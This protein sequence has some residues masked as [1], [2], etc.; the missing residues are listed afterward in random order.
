MDRPLDPPRGPTSDPDLDLRNEA[1][2]HPNRL[3]NTKELRAL[4]RELG[5]PDRNQLVDPHSNQRYVENLRAPTNQHNFLFGRMP[6]FESRLEALRAVRDEDIPKLLSLIS[7]DKEEIRANHRIACLAHR[8]KFGTSLADT[9]GEIL[10]NYPDKNR[11][12]GRTVAVTGLPGSGAKEVAADLTS[13]LNKRIGAVIAMDPDRTRF[14]LF[15]AAVRDVEVGA[16]NDTSWR[17][18]DKARRALHSPAV[19]QMVYTV[20]EL[21][22]IAL[23]ARGYNLVISQGPYMVP[24]PA[25]ALYAEHPTIELADV[26]DADFRGVFEPLSEEQSTSFYATRAEAREKVLY[27]TLQEMDRLRFPDDFP[28]QEITSNKLRTFEEMP[29]VNIKV[30]QDA[31]IQILMSLEKTLERDER[32]WDNITRIPNNPNAYYIHSL[33]DTITSGRL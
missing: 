8:L 6:H 33:A 1:S 32:Y 29:D 5:I 11:H 22:Q 24:P 4:V 2:T 14:G 15:A 31:C 12:Q 16:S 10:D 19:S 25:V 30:P 13:A 18:I 20:H 9:I 27:R 23:L 26:A 3:S 21:S 7:I 28:W 17:D